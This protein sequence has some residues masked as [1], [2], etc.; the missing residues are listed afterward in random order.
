MSVLKL[1]NFNNKFEDFVDLVS[2][3][4]GDGLEITPTDILVKI[5]QQEGIYNLYKIMHCLFIIGILNIDN[6]QFIHDSLKIIV[7]KPN[8]SVYEKD[9]IISFIGA[10][11]E[12]VYEDMLLLDADE[13][14]EALI[15]DIIQQI[16]TNL[17]SENAL[18]SK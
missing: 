13:L 3:Q 6:Y 17:N 10:K 12:L 4:E 2:A 16:Q 5:Q 14:Y 7:N 9:E 1:N 11:T 15:T 18:L 8:D